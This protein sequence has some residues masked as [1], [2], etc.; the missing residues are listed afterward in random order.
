MTYTYDKHHRQEHYVTAVQM[1][2][3]MP[4]VIACRCGW[5]RTIS[6]AYSGMQL[7]DMYEDHKEDR[8]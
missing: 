7:Q 8:P 4:L 2:G 3:G 1:Q 6:Q 5:L